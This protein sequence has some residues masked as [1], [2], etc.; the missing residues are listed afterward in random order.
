LGQPLFLFSPFINLTFSLAIPY[1]RNNNITTEMTRLILIFCFIIASQAMIFSVPKHSAGQSSTAH[2]E[3]TKTKMVFNSSA[4]HLPG[5]DSDNQNIPLTV[6][7]STFSHLPSTLYIYIDQEILC[8]FSIL[9]EIRQPETY[10]PPSPVA[11]SRF[12]VH[13]FRVIISSNAP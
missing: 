6:S 8:L 4:T 2:I 13:M 1:I 3:L 9:Y 10:Q 7:A 12:F 5:D 11:L